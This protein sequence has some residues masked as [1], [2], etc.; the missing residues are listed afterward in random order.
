M[1]KRVFL[2]K[3]F[4]RF[5]H[6]MQALMVI[7]LLYT[8]FEVHG[9][10]NFIDYQLAVDLHN[11]VVWIL[12]VL[13][14]FAIFWHFTTG[15]WRQYLPTK[16]YL[17]EMIRYYLVGIFKNEP[18]PAGKTEI[19]KLNPLQRLTYLGLKVLIFPVQIISGFAYYYYNDLDG[20]GIGIPLGVIAFVHTGAA[21]LMMAFVV[22]HVYL[23]TTGHTPLSNIKAMITGWEELETDSGKHRGETASL[24]S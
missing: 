19:S 22:A 1:K 13:I 11:M 6:W 16:Q 3:R 14:A 18:H 23:T 12:L 9:T 21:Y 5:W 4:E 10:F 8:G 2:Y 24:K 15:E 20:F 7:V 17:K